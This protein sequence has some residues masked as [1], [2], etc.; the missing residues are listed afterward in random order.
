MRVDAAEF[1]ALPLEAHALLDDVPLKDVNAVDLPGGGPGQTLRDVRAL[2]P[3]GGL[4]K[5]NLMTR[6][7]FGMRLWLGRLFS[8]DGPEHDRADASYLNRVSEAIRARSAAP[9]GTREGGF[10]QLYLLEQESLAEIRN[11]TVHAFLC[12]ALC[13]AGR[14]SS[15][16]GHLREAHVHVDP[17]VYGAYRAFP[18]VSGVSGDVQAAAPRLDRPL[19]AELSGAYAGSW[20]RLQEWASSRSGYFDPAAFLMVGDFAFTIRGAAFSG[21]TAAL[22]L[23]TGAGLPFSN[24]AFSPNF[25]TIFFFVSSPVA[26]MT[27]VGTRRAL[28][29]AT[30]LVIS[31]GGRRR[32]AARARRGPDCFTRFVRPRSNSAP[33]RSAIRRAIACEARAAAGAMALRTISSMEP[34]LATLGIP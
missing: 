1:R 4:M 29:S 8:W 32:T 17:R 14:V 18:A 6:A 22:A 12:E 34:S 31:H 24:A 5:A 19:P 30:H 25:A 10:R 33:A 15:L 21:A 11:A 9:P 27:K 3:P 28:R 23:A 20:V 7:L 13:A 16:L 26:S 2:I